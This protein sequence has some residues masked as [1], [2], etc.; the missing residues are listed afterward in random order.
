MN[1]FRKTAVVERNDLIAVSEPFEC[2]S[3]IALPDT[4][5]LSQN[6]QSKYK[7]ILRHFQDP[8]LVV[9]PTE[10]HHTESKHHSEGKQPLTHME[11]FWLTRECLM[12]YLRAAKGD[13]EHAVERIEY[14]LAWRREFGVSGDDESVFTSGSIKHENKTGKQV[15][16]GFDKTGRP[17][18]YFKPGRQNTKTSI[19]QVQSTVWF[20]ERAIDMMPAGQENLSL[21]IDYKAYKVEGETS[22]VPP[23]SVG[24]QVLHILQSHYP[25][26]LGKAMFINLPLVAITFLKLITPFL[27]P[28][29]KEKLV[30]DT[31][32]N[33]VVD[34]DQLDSDY[35]GGIE[36][37]IRSWCLL[38]QSCWFDRSD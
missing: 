13:V 1:F 29:T 4:K 34:D 20:L 11:K 12:R 8:E 37:W 22:K 26:R 9:S 27:D 21:L 6:D 23:L 32:F 3:T 18:L 36:V 17:L 16:L 24:R 33:V 10:Q 30:F 5:R 14:T 31:H 35:Q 28:V 15:L 19:K 2:P 25:E 38:W 7:T